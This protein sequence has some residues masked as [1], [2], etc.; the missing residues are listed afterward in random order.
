MYAEGL[1]DKNRFDPIHVSGNSRL[2]I[3]QHKASHD[4]YDMRLQQGDIA[5]SWVIRK[6]PGEAD[7]MLAVRQPTHT[8]EYMNFEGTIG[9]GYGAGTVKKV[10]DHPVDIIQSNDE[11][12]KLVLPEGEHTMI[13]LKGDKDW[14]IVKNKNT[15]PDPTTTKIEMKDASN[16]E[17]D[18][19]DPNKIFQPKMDGGHTLFRLR[20][21]G[22]NRIYSYR[23]STKTGRPIE[24][25]HQVPLMRDAN[26]PSDLD[27]V[28]F[29]GELYGKTRDGKPMPVQDVAGILNSGIWNSRK[30]QGEKGRLEPYM[31]KIVKWKDGKNVEDAPYSQHIEMMKEIASKVPNFHMPEI[32][33]TPDKKRELFNQIKAKKHPETLEGIVQYDLN[34]AGGDPKKVKLRDTHEVVIREIFPAQTKSGK[35]MA[36]GFA[37]SWKPRSEIVG[38][39]GTGFTEAVR[40]DMLKDPEKYIGRVARI[41]AQQIFESGA[42]RAPSYYGLHIEKNLMEK[43]AYNMISELGKKTLGMSRKEMPQIRD[44]H[45]FLKHLKSNG[46]SHEKSVVSPDSLRPTQKHIDSKKVE[47]FK[48]DV[49][50][51]HVVV[52]KDGHIVDGHHRWA[53]AVSDDEIN[54]LKIVKIDMPIKS[55]INKAH[56]FSKAANMI[57][58]AASPE[59]VGAGIAGTGAAVLGAGAFLLGRRFL[60]AGASRI[61]KRAV[62]PVVEK[63][64]AP[65]ATSFITPAAQAARMGTASERA[66][67]NARASAAVVKPQQPVATFKPNPAPANPNAVPAAARNASMNPQVAGK[68]A[69]MAAAPTPPPPPAPAPMATQQNVQPFV[70]KQKFTNLGNNQFQKVAHMAFNDELQ[71]IAI[72]E[73]AIRRALRNRISNVQIAKMESVLKNVGNNKERAIQDLD[74]KM[75]EARSYVNNISKSGLKDVVRLTQKEFPKKQYLTKTALHPLMEL[76]MAGAEVGSLVGAA[77][78][79]P[80]H[81]PG[82]LK[83]SL[84]EKA[85]ISAVAGAALTPIAATMI[86][87]FKKFRF[88]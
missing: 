15:I 74:A 79:I 84:L 4:H 39:V 25:S 3:Q 82:K 57:K 21:N 58:K 8:S 31:F 37:Y 62:A 13:K 51:K 46:V 48:D 49:M 34:A 12:I 19:N 73:N 14:L 33:D 9:P 28:E 76:S 75:Y 44:L 27:G 81:K 41:K 56:E 66:A 55:L 40:K 6:L 72:S 52:A 42:A 23:I 53:K 22:P 17:L 80:V 16:K 29:R 59:A 70:P 47:G 43:N 7:K 35:Q 18:F 65:V 26:V 86:Q 60:G 88:K 87:K 67:I 2:V 54:K 61:A 68:P 64:A 1:P 36:G 63:A 5:H 30:L 32:A 78:A 10:Y 77:I 69:P 11:R 20:S 50:N 71:K 45:G 83:D 38:R 24:H 85:E